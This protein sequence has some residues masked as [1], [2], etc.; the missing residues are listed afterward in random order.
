MRPR[1]QAAL[2]FLRLASE[3]FSIGIRFCE[4]IALG[5]Q[6]FDGRGQVGL[7]LVCVEQGAIGILKTL[8]SP[9]NVGFQNS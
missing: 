6:P 2:Y 4:G 5:F 8:T 1:I 3:S 9:C 7:L